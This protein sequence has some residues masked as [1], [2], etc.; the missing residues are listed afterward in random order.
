MKSPD[1]ENLHAGH[2]ERLRRRFAEEGLDGFDDHNALELLLSYAIPRR[3]VNG[4]AHELIRR[5]GSFDGV[6][7]APLYELAAVDGVGERSALLIKLVP[8]LT[9]KYQLSRIKRSE[10]E[11]LDDIARTG[12]Y[13]LPFFYAVEEE[14]VYLATLD[15]KRR[16]IG[17]RMLGSGREAFASVTVKSVLEAALRDRAFAVILAHNHPSGV[18]V[19]SRDDVRSTEKLMAALAPLDIKLDDHIIVAGNEFASMKECGYM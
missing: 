1:K 7:D 8:Q 15:P 9:R 19:P 5:F 18:A 4:L 14:T 11:T 10:T 12:K 6:F 3:D 2:R 16:V 13:F 17:C